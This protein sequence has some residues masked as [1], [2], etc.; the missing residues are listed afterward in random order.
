MS[1]IAAGLVLGES[2]KLLT[3]ELPPGDEE[4]Y[5]VEVSA[6]LFLSECHLSSQAGETPHALCMV[7]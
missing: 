4:R 3:L 6:R 7:C 2:R 1:L 5:E